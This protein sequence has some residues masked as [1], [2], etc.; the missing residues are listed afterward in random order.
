MS[1][2]LR[3]KERCVYCLKMLPF[4]LENKAKVKTIKVLFLKVKQFIIWIKCM[5]KLMCS[6]CNSTEG[7]IAVDG[8]FA[9]NSS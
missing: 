3:L 2:Q 5:K 6:I 1:A 7:F 9:R 4:K 8:I